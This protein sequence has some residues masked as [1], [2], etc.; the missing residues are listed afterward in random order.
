MEPLAVSP[1]LVY[2]PPAVP[3]DLRSS[4]YGSVLWCAL[5]CSSLLLQHF[6]DEPDVG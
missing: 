5:Q 4:V 1:H 2:V 6:A 3:W